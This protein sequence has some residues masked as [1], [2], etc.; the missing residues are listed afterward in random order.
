[1]KNGM[2][3]HTVL[4]ILLLLFDLSCWAIGNGTNNN[5]AAHTFMAQAQESLL[6]RERQKAADIL[7]RAISDAKTLSANDRDVLLRELGRV[8]S[9]FFTNEGQ[10]NF[11][12][13][14][15]IRLNGEQGYAPKYEAALLQEDGNFVVLVGQT[16]A[17]F[18]N[19][20]CKAAQANIELIG[21]LYP[22]SAE[23]KVLRLKADICLTAPPDTAVDEKNLEN[24]ANKKTIVNALL[25][26]KY[27]QQ[28]NYD[29]ALVKA[30]ESM[31]AD[32]LYPS[33]FYWAWRIL[34]KNENEGLDEAQTFLGLCKSIDMKL[35]KKY[36]LD[37]ELCSGTDQVE[38]FIRKIE[39]GGT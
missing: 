12:L 14:E 20:N 13:A 39:G 5:G 1:M 24:I 26:Q 32:P 35:R 38:E 33:G 25:A 17:F 19:K 11:E 23:Y 22:Q 30:R 10:R 31:R 21:K 4:F 27:Y 3:R 6:K 9:L 29:L 2:L 18:A 8:N 7:S 36:Y 15:S 34:E 28:K 37:P 16:L